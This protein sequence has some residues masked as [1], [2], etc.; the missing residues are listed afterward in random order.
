MSNPPF[1]IGNG[2][3]VHA[4]VSGRPLVV[5]GVTIPYDRGLDG[6]SDA[7][8]LLHAITDALL[9]ATALGDLGRHFPD[10]DPRWKGADS[11]ALM[12]NVMALV[13]N[14][15]Y[16]VSNIDATLIAQ[17][18]RFAAFIDA[19]RDNIAC[20]MRCDIGCVSVKATTTEQLGFSG[21]GEG[22]AAQAVVLLAARETS[23]T[24]GPN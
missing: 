8:V 1:R 14:S 12:R 15:G 23:G 13:D 16:A 21:R 10:T 24:Q 2:F 6:H 19:M 11:R 17:A 3:D 7:D 4:L 5:G 9:G 18:P 20:D 22:I